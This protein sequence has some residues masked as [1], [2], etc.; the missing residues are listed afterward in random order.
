MGD[1]PAAAREPCCVC[2][3]PA[4]K[5]CAKCKSRHYCSKACQLDRLLETLMPA[6]LKFKEEPAI[7][8]GP[9]RAYL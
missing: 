7:V 3:A 2:H 6:K 4:G 9:Q 1:P 5:H 8:Q